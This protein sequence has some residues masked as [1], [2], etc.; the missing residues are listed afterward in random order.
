MITVGRKDRA[1][2]DAA[3]RARPLTQLEV[4]EAIG[5]SRAR[6]FQLERRAIEKIRR[7]IVEQ[8]AADGVSVREWLFGEA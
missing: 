5:V 1:T 7:F 4:A 8:A 6:V 3:G 2:A